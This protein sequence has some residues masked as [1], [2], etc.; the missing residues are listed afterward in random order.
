MSQGFGSRPDDRFSSRPWR[1]SSW[2]DHSLHRSEGRRRPGGDLR[3]KETAGPSAPLRLGWLVFVAL[4]LVL[5]YNAGPLIEQAQY[6]YQRGRLRAES[7]DATARLE[8]MSELNVSDTSLTFPLIVQRVKPCVVQI[9]T[10]HERP[11]GED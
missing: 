2:L 3:P 1:Q 7:E 11:R 6:A 4:M 10:L 5:L 8:K 9:E